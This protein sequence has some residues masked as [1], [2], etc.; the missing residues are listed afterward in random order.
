[1]MSCMSFLRR[2]LVGRMVG[3]PSRFGC[4]FEGAAMPGECSDDR[5]PIGRLSPLPAPETSLIIRRSQVRALQGPCFLF[6]MLDRPLVGSLVDFIAR[7]LLL[8]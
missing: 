4:G 2:R 3:F 7:S 8:G 6:F 1:V 5:W